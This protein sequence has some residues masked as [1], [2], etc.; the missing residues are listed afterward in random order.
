VQSLLMK[1]QQPQLQEANTSFSQ[2]AEM[3]TRA[4][5]ARS[6]G[7]EGALGTMACHPHCL[8]TSST[9]SRI[10]GLLSDR[11]QTSEAHCFVASWAAEEG[12]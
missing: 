1:Q 5:P 3:A 7:H 4:A 9:V 11:Q 8:K 6:A 2:D 12:Q 10:Q